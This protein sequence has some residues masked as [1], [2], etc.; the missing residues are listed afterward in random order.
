M[1]GQDTLQEAAIISP[2]DLQRYK[3]SMRK[4][5]R[6]K[7]DVFCH[8]YPFAQAEAVNLGPDG[9][10]LAIQGLPTSRN[11]YLEVEFCLRDRR[12]LKLYRLPVYVADS[13]DQGTDLRFVETYMSAFRYVEGEPESGH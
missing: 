5:V 7:V 8:G 13:T 11:T 10:F 3:E 12:G 1:F 2:E 4:P 9:L 6:L